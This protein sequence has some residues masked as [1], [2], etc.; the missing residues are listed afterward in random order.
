MV[1][2]DVVAVSVRRGLVRW[3]VHGLD[4]IFVTTPGRNLVLS[5]AA[6][7]AVVVGLTE[8]ADSFPPEALRRFRTN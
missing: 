2:G 4:L 5:A 7:S 6:A 8:I 1:T 3:R